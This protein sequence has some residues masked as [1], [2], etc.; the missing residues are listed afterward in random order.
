MTLVPVEWVDGDELP[1]EKHT[2]LPQSK[3][4]VFILNKAYH[5]IFQ[6][7]GRESWSKSILPSSKELC[8]HFS[9]DMW[10]T[11]GRAGYSIKAIYDNVQLVTIQKNWRIFSFKY[12]KKL[13]RAWDMDKKG[14]EIKKM[15]WKTCSFSE[16][17]I[18][19]MFKKGE[20]M[21]LN[22]D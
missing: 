18:K 12:F 17:I 6:G 11:L 5:K 14:S 21:W 4:Q 2:E 16:C 7:N 1:L 8:Y 15:E 19:H 13:K 22:Q 3:E 10:H 9:S 20:N